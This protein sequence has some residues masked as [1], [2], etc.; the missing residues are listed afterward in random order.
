[1]LEAWV[2]NIVEEFWPSLTRVGFPLSLGGTA[3]L[4]CSCVSDGG[5]HSQMAR[6]TGTE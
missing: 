1:M 3:L 2:M 4:I 5:C 6:I